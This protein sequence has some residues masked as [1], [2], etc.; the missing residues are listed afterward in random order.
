MQIDGEVT[1]KRQIKVPA[2]FDDHVVGKISQLRKDHVH[3]KNTDDIRA[4]K[5]GEKEIG[6]DEVV[7]NMIG[8]GTKETVEENRLGEDDGVSK[9]TVAEACAIAE[10]NENDKGLE[11]G[12]ETSQNGMGTVCNI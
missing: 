12:N 11:A 10:V 7:T 3:N 4:T 1:N 8:K 5:L 2:K 6:N 9:D